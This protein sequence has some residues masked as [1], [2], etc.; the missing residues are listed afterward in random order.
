MESADCESGNRVIACRNQMF[1]TGSQTKDHGSQQRPPGD[2]PSKTPV[3]TILLWV[4]IIVAAAATFFMNQHKGAVTSMTQAEFLDGLAS[5]Q[6][7]NATVI[8]N[9]QTMP[10]VEITG[11]FS[12]A[13]KSG[14]AT[15]QVAFVVHNFLLAGDAENKLSHS[16]RITM[17][18][19]NS[20]VANVIWGLAPFLVLAGLFWFFIVRQ[21]GRKVE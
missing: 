15:N 16:P 5:N 10:L 8:V 17:Q 19:A 21:A 11:T 7:V 6:I 13:G 3:L 9:Q 2:T 4:G 12:D 14:S 20:A 18:P 1:D